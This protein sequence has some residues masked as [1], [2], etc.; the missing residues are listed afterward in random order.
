MTARTSEEDARLRRLRWLGISKSTWDRSDNPAHQY[1]WYYDVPELG[2]KAHL[3]DIAAGIGLAQLEKLE[4][5]NGRRRAITQVYN[6]AF[7]DLDWLRTPVVKPYAESSHHMYVV[8]TPYRDALHSH[9]RSVGVSTSVH[10]IPSTQ[11]EMYAPYRR[12]LPVC[13]RV[14]KEILTLPL[15]PGLTDADIARVIEGVRS[16]VPAAVAR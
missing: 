14:W 1:S 6:D 11:Y 10:Y 2:Y 8:S 4:Q 12:P 9:L 16:F 3:N 15:Y 7:R 5:A 13:D